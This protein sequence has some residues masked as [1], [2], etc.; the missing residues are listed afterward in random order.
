MFSSLRAAASK[1][2][3]MSAPEEPSVPEPPWGLPSIADKFRLAE[4]MPPAT[5]S[6]AASL[7]SVPHATGGSTTS[8]PASTCPHCEKPIFNVTLEEFQDHVASCSRPSSADDVAST[9]STLTEITDGA[10]SPARNGRLHDHDDFDPFDPDDPFD[11]KAPELSELAIKSFGASKKN[12]LGKFQYGTQSTHVRP[13]TNPQHE[14][15]YFNE[16]DGHQQNEEDL[17]DPHSTSNFRFPKLTDL[18]NFT[19]YLDDPDDMDPERLYDRTKR[20]TAVLKAYQDEFDAIEKEVNTYETYQKSEAERI[21]LEAKEVDAQK[22]ADDKIREELH[23]ALE[24]QRMKLMEF[25]TQ[26]SRRWNDAIA[27]HDPRLL[28]LIDVRIDFETI[29]QRKR[30]EKLAGKPVLEYAPL[31]EIKPTKEEIDAEKRKRGRVMSSIKFNDMNTADVYGFEYN[32]HVKYIGAQPVSAVAIKR[33]GANGIE[34]SDG[35]RLRAQ[36]Q[37][38]RKFYEEN[39]PETESDGLPAKRT[40]KPRNLDETDEV[41]GRSRPASHSRGATPTPRTFPSGKKVG[42]PSKADVL[43]RSKLS[44]IMIAPTSVTPEPS[45]ASG[46][47][48]RGAQQLTDDVRDDLQNAAA[49][50]VAAVS[51]E[52]KP[53]RK[54]AGGRPRGS[55]KGIGGRPRKVP[56]PEDAQA[57]TNGRR[58]VKKEADGSFDMNGVMPSTEEE[59]DEHAQKSSDSMSRPST[60]SSSVTD[61]SL[62]SRRSSRPQ[63]QAK[64]D[65]R[66]R[67]AQMD[68]LASTYK[69]DAKRKRTDEPIDI[70]SSGRG[71]RTK[72]AHHPFDPS[73][74]VEVESKSARGTKR[75]NGNIDGFD[76]GSPSSKK[77]KIR[78][79]RDEAN[80]IDEQ[81]EGEFKGPKRKR[82]PADSTLMLAEISLTPST[83]P[84]K[85]KPRSKKPKPKSAVDVPIEEYEPDKRS[86]DGRHLSLIPDPIE[87][88]A[89]RKR[90]VKRGKSDKLSKSMH[91]RWN[92]GRM[93][94]AMATRKANAEK[95]KVLGT[96]GAHID[97]NAASTAPT[98]T[99]A[100]VPELVRAA[101]TN[102]LKQQARKGKGKAKASH[103]DDEDAIY[104]SSVADDDEDLDDDTPAPQQPIQTRRTSTRERKKPLRVLNGLDGADDE[105]DDDDEEDEEEVVP[106]PPGLER[107]FMSEYEHYQ[108]LTSPGAAIRLG[109]RVKRQINFAEELE[110]DMDDYY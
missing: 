78:G 82:A 94:E 30:E 102:S 42:R 98:P 109:K 99:P 2:P 69:R 47:P 3:A 96:N 67:R 38:T 51:P 59:G 16:A 24:E 91:A 11:A 27:R 92:D 105:E 66:E 76:E 12:V 104:D 84:P 40:R 101:S 62:G 33:R 23:E 93:E 56:R 64:T 34:V 68:D 103:E 18:E 1:E 29:A 22:K 31:P 52:V 58:G 8:S 32:P 15:D 5:S 39:S 97:S 77:R 53:K 50:I 7:L 19:K 49:G 107:Q 95:K 83:D 26:G 54:G 79:P 6:P 10:D 35:G 85:K 20:V 13:Y 65:A 28:A 72:T 17:E 90:R 45:P 74:S 9:I 55:R 48:A 71:K 21:I 46:G 60:A 14:F 37:P 63:T 43:A 44:N 100:S 87:R 80:G 89:V 4:S 36:R 106:R 25:G 86:E 70:N 61:G 108:A 110:D 75:Q 88:E 41:V 57:Q 73:S 81:D